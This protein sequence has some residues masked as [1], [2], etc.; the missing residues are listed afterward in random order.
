MERNGEVGQQVRDDHRQER[1]RQEAGRLHRP[2]MPDGSLPRRLG[3][4]SD[5]MARL[6]Q[7]PNW[8]K[9]APMGT[10]GGTVKEGG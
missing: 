7:N 6:P 2:G 1:E 10:K 5:A 4:M 3:A 8:E 9:T